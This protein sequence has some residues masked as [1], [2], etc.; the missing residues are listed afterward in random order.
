MK[1]EGSAADRRADK[2]GAKKAGFSMAKWERSAADRKQ[3]AAGR[4]K[5][6]KRGR[7]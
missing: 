6:A 3:D 1:Y 4:K 7:K 5:M 2:K